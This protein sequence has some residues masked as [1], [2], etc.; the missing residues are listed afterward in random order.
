VIHPSLIIRCSNSFRSL[1]QTKPQS[2]SRMWSVLPSFLQYR[3]GGASISAS[4]PMRGGVVDF[5][6]GPDHGY[7]Y[8]GHRGIYRY[9]DTNTLQTMILY[10]LKHP[11]SCIHTG[12]R[13]IPTHVTYPQYVTL[14]FV[15]LRKYTSSDHLDHFSAASR[16]N[17]PF[18]LADSKATLCKGRRI[19]GSSKRDNL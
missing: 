7:G 10:I 11:Q 3:I 6:G 4:D 9:I 19:G 18:C 15:H 12:N 17:S 1:Q 16:S 8:P 13:C 2:I 5:Y 14:A